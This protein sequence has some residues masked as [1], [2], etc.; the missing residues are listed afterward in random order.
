MNFELDMNFDW[1]P[2]KILTGKLPR[3]L[4]KRAKKEGRYWNGKFS[5]EAKPVLY[6][7]MD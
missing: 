2:V 3:K 6:I 5:I 1:K 7:Q 4:K